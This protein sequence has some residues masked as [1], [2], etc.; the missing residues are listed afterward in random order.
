MLA[1]HLNQRTRLG[2]LLDPAADK[3]LMVSGYIFYTVWP[4]LPRVGI[5]VWLTFVVFIRDFMIAVVAYLLYTRVQVKRFPPTRAGKAATLLQAAALGCVIE[6][7]AFGPALMWLAQ[8][9][10]RIALVVTLY[11]SWDYIRR[12]RHLLAEGMAARR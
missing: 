9:L 5:P 8:A 4:H 1:R 10:F 12:G 7:N 6:V 11:S 2:A 3:L